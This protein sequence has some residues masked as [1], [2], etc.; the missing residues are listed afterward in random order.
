MDENT[1]HIRDTTDASFVADVIEA[2]K[3]QPV[4][5]DFW[6][7]WCGPCRQLMPVLEKLVNAE[8]GK[9][10]MVKVNIDENQMI[11]GQLRVQSVPTVYAFKNGEPVDGFMGAQPESELKKF[12]GKLT[13][14]TDVVAEA[15][16]LVERA[17]ASLEA[18][19]IGGAAQDYA[20]ALQMNP[21]CA[22]AL[23]GLARLSL[24]NGDTE[25]AKSMIDSAPEAMQN[26]PDIASVRAALSL[27]EGVPADEEDD[28]ELSGL[29]AAVDAHPDDL[30][31][32]LAL[33]KALAAKGQNAE[34]VE[35]LLYSIEK[36]RG[37]DDEA[38]RKFLLTIFEAEGVSSPIAQDGR[39]RLAS[40]LFA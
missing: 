36:N 27:S 22:E 10:K 12:I 39:K 15:A 21:E 33:A 28:G 8:N 1:P 37:H 19:D 29:Q 40:I 3:I 6:A 4:I 25:T 23:A 5:V 31:A 32:R 11:A 17:K 9:V 30:D 24:E 14:D 13:G 38:A 34:A 16:A 26:H 7:P 35:H 2:S 18:G 20:S